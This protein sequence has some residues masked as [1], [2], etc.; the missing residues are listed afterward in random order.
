MICEI[1]DP[2]VDKHSIKVSQITAQH[3]LATVGYTKVRA[4]W[5]A[6]QF[7]DKNKR[8]QVDTAQEFLVQHAC[9]LTMISC[10]INDDEL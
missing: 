3:I 1:Q 6:K 2:L 7:T 9:D 5:I 10:I 8:A 4:K